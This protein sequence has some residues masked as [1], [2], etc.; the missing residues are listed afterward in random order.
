MAER[1][2][3]TRTHRRTSDLHVQNNFDPE[4]DR[5]AFGPHGLATG[6]STARV[7]SHMCAAVFSC[8]TNTLQGHASID[9]QTRDRVTS[10]VAHATHATVTG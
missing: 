10:L 7:R 9:P 2:H 3:P 1:S 4:H 8:T 5:H 6:S